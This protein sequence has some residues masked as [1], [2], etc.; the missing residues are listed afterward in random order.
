MEADKEECYRSTALA[1]H[2][3]DPFLVRQLGKGPHLPSLTDV[4]GEDHA[5]LGTDDSPDLLLASIHLH[6][7]NLV[8]LALLDIKQRL[9]QL[10]HD[11]LLH[12]VPS[13]K[14]LH[15][16]KERL[17]ISGHRR[18]ERFFCALV[19][20][21]TRPEGKEGTCTEGWLGLAA[22]LQPAD[23]WCVERRG[24][25]AEGKGQGEARMEQKR[26]ASPVE[27]HWAPA[28]NPVG[29]TSESDTGTIEEVGPASCTLLSAPLLK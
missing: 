27:K 20:A 11:E 9:F 15:G 1:C 29:T 22:C 8:V 3:H 5:H 14:I 12:K 24:V 25:Q 17:T 2:D 7:H 19:A 16:R 28:R 26:D 10:V 18:N 13:R 21:C 23:R 6:I 4:A